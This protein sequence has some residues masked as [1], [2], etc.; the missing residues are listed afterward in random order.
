MQE[1]QAEKRIGWLQDIWQMEI[2][3]MIF[4]PCTLY[5]ITKKED[6]YKTEATTGELSTKNKDVKFFLLTLIGSP[7]IERIY[8]K[9]K[10][11]S[12][13]LKLKYVSLCPIEN[14]FEGMHTS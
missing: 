1:A 5:D 4:I 12:I 2:S 9:C 13:K 6:Q 8:M 14:C 3:N 11:Y 10:N 7:L